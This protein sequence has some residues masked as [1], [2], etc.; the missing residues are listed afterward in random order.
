MEIFLSTVIFGFIFILGAIFGSF[1]NV[2]I[3]RYHSG[4]TFWGRSM[5]FSCGKTLAWHDLIPILSFARLRGKCRFCRSKIS[6]QYAAI[7]GITGLL[8]ALFFWKTGGPAMFQNTTSILYFINLGFFFAI[9]N[10]LVVIVGYDVKHKIIPDVFAYGFAAL[11]LSKLFFLPH[12][13]ATP[14]D[15][16]AGPILAI[17]FAFL[18]SVSGGR[19]MGLGDAKLALGIGWFLGLW[20]GFV[21]IIIAFWIGAIF[22][23]TLIVFG[24]LTQASFFASIF[25]RR[26]T[27][28]SEIPFAPFL[29]LG[30][31]L[32]FFFNINLPF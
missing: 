4:T 28:K 6:W 16:L 27:M 13:N 7:E 5:C 14:L 25:R 10:F 22:G 29:I 20:S 24:K 23:I 9:A 11:A 1:L 2:V 3:F 31:L 26:I 18:W 32:V 30:T 17:P 8:F 19:W 12:F 15:F 21:A